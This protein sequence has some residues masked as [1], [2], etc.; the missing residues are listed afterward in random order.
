MTTTTAP[1]PILYRT[2]TGNLTRDPGLRF[3]PKGTS[4]GTC[5]LAVNRHTRQEDGTWSEEP[6]EFYEL[7]CFGDLAEHVAE[8]LVKGDRVIATGKL[9]TDRWT[10]RDGTERTTYKLVCDDIGPSLRPG[11]VEVNRTTRWG[12]GQGAGRGGSARD[13]SA[14]DQIATTM[15]ATTPGELFGEDEPF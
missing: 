4:W 15:A 3:S 13:Q 2:L 14:R 7:V 10:G 9:E 12:P 8:C 11:T 6:P 5:G 1:A